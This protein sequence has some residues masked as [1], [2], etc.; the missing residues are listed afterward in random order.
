MDK[1]RFP[2]TSVTEEG[3][4]IDVTVPGDELGGDAARDL[5]PGAIRVCGTLSGLG[6]E[7]FFRGAVSGT[8]I[9]ACDRCLL[10]VELPFS[11][12]VVWRFAERSE[13][14]PLETLND[15]ENEDDECYPCPGGVIDLAERAWEEVVLAFPVKFVACED[16]PDLCPECGADPAQRAYLEADG[17][18]D[19]LRN[20]GLAG[21]GELFPGLR[22]TDSE[23]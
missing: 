9:R 2:F 10:D 22:S 4:P 21:L 6:H 1:L 3:L 16:R 20:K 8:F 18:E 14:H 7:W 11:S 19:E 17:R 13:P 12:E 15:E 23:E 5:R